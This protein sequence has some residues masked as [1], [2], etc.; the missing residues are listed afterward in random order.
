MV[1]AGLLWTWFTVYFFSQNTDIII[2]W[3]HPRWCQVKKI[4]PKLTIEQCTCKVLNTLNVTPFADISMISVSFLKCPSCSRRKLSSHNVLF[5]RDYFLRKVT[6]N[7][8]WARTPNDL[9][10]PLSTPVPLRWDIVISIQ[11]YFLSIFTYFLST[12]I[13]LSAQPHSS[14]WRSVYPTLYDGNIDQGCVT[15][16]WNI[17]QGHSFIRI[18]YLG[19][20][21]ISFHES[22]LNVHFV[23]SS[24]W[25]PPFTWY[26]PQ[27]WWN[28][29]LCCD[30]C[31]LIAVFN[32]FHRYTD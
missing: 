31:D 11:P 17:E 23:L 29:L 8:G 30:V 14:H 32:I 13:F 2:S 12:F 7:R 6:Q 26:F 16:L 22:F 25:R 24:C 15:Y 4:R 21:N 1:M 28:L 5:S 10:D 9:T 18:R 27:M 19:L 20:S 3:Q